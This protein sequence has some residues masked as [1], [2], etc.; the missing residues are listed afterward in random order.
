MPSHPASHPQGW[1]TY[2]AVLVLLRG[3]VHSGVPRVGPAGVDLSGVQLP[4]P[5]RGEEG[6]L[7]TG[8]A[9]RVSPDACSV[10]GPERA[11]RLQG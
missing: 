10:W 8:S 7:G 3:V 5:E 2:H 11:R 9:P 4:V 1:P 6:V